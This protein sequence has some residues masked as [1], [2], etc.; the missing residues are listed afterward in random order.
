MYA[1]DVIWSR[2]PIG[3]SDPRN[4]APGRC[5]SRRPSRRRRCRWPAAR[6]RAASGFSETRSS[7]CRA[8]HIC[9]NGFL[10]TRPHRGTRAVNSETAEVVAGRLRH[11][12]LDSRKRRNAIHQSGDPGLLW[13]RRANDAVGV[14][15]H[16]DDSTL[17]R[18][19]DSTTHLA[20]DNSDDH[21]DRDEQGL[22]QRDL[23]DNEHALQPRT[24]D[25]PPPVSG[26]GPECQLTV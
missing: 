8:F 23:R 6:T 16:A 3:S 14:E 26:D 9:A 21:R 22:C 19:V 12:R 4:R 15:L 1:R 17:Q 7:R 5:R 13:L 20:D 24:A 10:R 18:V 2:S 25:V 11:H